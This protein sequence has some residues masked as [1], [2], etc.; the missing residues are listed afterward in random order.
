MEIDNDSMATPAVTC[1]LVNN[2]LS[3]SRTRA[4]FKVHDPATQ[5]LITRVP[6]S[7]ILE[8]QKAV[9]AAEAAQPAWALLSF[10]KRRHKMLTLLDI[11]RENTAKIRHCLCSEVGKT[12]ADADAE[13]E[14][15]LDAIETACAISNEMFG[16]HMSTGATEVHTLHEPLGVCVAITPFNFPLLIPLWSIPYALLTGNT[17]VLKPSEKTPTAAM[18]LANYFVQAGFPPGVFNVVHGSSSVVDVLLSQ[19]AVKAITFVGSDVAGERVYE[20]ARATRKRVQVECGG[21]NH[22]VVLEDA[23][24][25]QTLYAI[26]GSAFGAAGQRCMALSVILFVGSTKDWIAD[27]V[28]VARS[29]VIGRGLEEGVDVGPLITPA[30]KERVEE[31]VNSAEAEGAQVLLDGRNLS[32][33]RYADG[34]FFGPT[35]LSK[36]RT[37]MQCYQEEIFGPVLACMEVASLD[38]AVEI[39]NENRYGNGCTLFTA[40]PVSARAFQQSVNIGQ[41]GIN[42]PVLATSGPVLRTSNKDSFLGGRSMIV[43]KPLFDCLRC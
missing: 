21:K 30:A 41:I 25:T 17:F 32:V 1:N 18:L 36:V 9:A 20:H 14:R 24:K 37:Y 40:S 6:N 13:I 38:E 28:E 10:S 3:F 22:G 43:L 39:V 4:W 8:V 19:P 7:T 34:N 15:G 11:I 33:D 23:S 35:I 27:L 16:I 2:E 31:I 29:L 42:V 5:N 12:L 26:A